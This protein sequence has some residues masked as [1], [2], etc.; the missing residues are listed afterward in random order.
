MYA[1]SPGGIE[2]GLDAHH[3]T[4]KLAFTPLREGAGASSK[5]QRTA[6]N[7]NISDAKPQGK[8]SKGK[9][10]AGEESGRKGK[11]HMTTLPKVK[12]K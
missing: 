3:I 4:R 10:L 6:N 9:G 8:P 12:L 2:P 5:L 11:H 1:K 7:L